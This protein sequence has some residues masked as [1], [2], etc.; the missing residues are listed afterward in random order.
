M[1]LIKTSF[2]TISFF[3]LGL[4]FM[5]LPV[6]VP[7]ESVASPPASITPAVAK[8]PQRIVDDEP[9]LRF[10]ARP[11]VQPTAV[12]TTTISLP[13]LYPELAQII[14]LEDLPA[15]EA[16]LTLQ[17]LIRD[18]DQAHVPAVVGLGKQAREGSNDELAVEPVEAL[19]DEALV[20]L[21]R[22]EQGAEYLAL[23]ENLRVVFKEF[24]ILGE[25]SVR[26]ARAALAAEK[27]G[28]Y[29]PLHFAL[30]TTDDLS[31]DGIMRA[32]SE[33]GL[34]TTQL[35]ADMGAPEI[36]AELGADVMAGQPIMM[37]GA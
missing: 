30:M 16:L 37:L 32:A 36:E 19:L 28:L 7:D 11:D 21:D 13:D 10:E 14:A 18:A 31:M 1:D 26:A 12:E 22:A 4:A 8:S 6:S 25:D 5:P 9:E 24:P 33:V 3:S 34:D 29:L 2:L 15:S 23:D 17:L 20:G 35:A 27:Q